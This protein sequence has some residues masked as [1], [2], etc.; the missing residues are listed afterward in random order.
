MGDAEPRLVAQIPGA[1]LFRAELPPGTPDCA[2]DRSIQVFC[3]KD[4][5]VFAGLD[6]EER[7]AVVGSVSRTVQ[8]TEYHYLRFR[9]IRAALDARR[10]PFPG[11]VQFDA[12]VDALHCELQAFCGAVRTC[13]DEIVYL[14]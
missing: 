6:P 3:A 2:S 14:T 4:S 5:P 13:V 11:E 1:L 12:L 7:F 8:R 9:E 10:A